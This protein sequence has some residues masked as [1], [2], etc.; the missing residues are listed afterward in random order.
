ML[1]FCQV[2]SARVFL[3]IRNDNGTLV[4]VQV[5]PRYHSCQRALRGR[6]M[7]CPYAAGRHA[8]T[9]PRAA[10]SKQYPVADMVREQLTGA[11]EREDF[12]W[13]SLAFRFSFALRWYCGGIGASVPGAFFEIRQSTGRGQSHGTHAASEA[14]FGFPGRVYQPKGI[15]T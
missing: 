9:L 12:W 7:A 5:V 8:D 4:P 3:S 6:P 15:L 11:V 14:G 10:P 1:C 2:A 13:K